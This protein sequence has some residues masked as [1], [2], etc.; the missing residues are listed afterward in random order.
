MLPVSCAEMMETYI[1]MI[2]TYS[3]R[4]KVLRTAGYIAS[5]LSGSVK[6]EETAKKLVTVSRQISN[7][8]I[9]LRFFDDILMWRITRHWSA[10]VYSVVM[11]SEFCLLLH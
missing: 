4:D 8:R 1:S 11:L 5:L 3:G 7:S 9:I 6:N 10:E 2:Q